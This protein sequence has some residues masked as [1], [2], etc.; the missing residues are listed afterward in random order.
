MLL[1]DYAPCT[2][3]RISSNDLDLE[4]SCL[5]NRPGCDPPEKPMRRARFGGSRRNRKSV[6][7]I[8]VQKTKEN[9][10][11]LE[12]LMIAGGDSMTSSIGSEDSATLMDMPIV[13]NSPKLWP[14]ENVLCIFSFHID[15]C[16]FSLV[17]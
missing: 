6:E 12:G 15:L 3:Q 11:V 10:E 17:F 7:I 2:L 16:M 9:G 8:P 4:S 1:C 13:E 5:L 14:R